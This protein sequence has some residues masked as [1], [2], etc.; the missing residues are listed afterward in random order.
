M[1]KMSRKRVGFTLIE[2]LIVIAILG[3]LAVV[4]LVLINPG[5]RQAQARDAGRVSSVAQ[6]GRSIQAYYTVKSNLPDVATWA[7][8]LVTTGEMSVFPSGIAY[9]YN[10]VSACTTYVQPATFPTYCYNEDEANGNGAIIYSKAEST[11]YRSK[12]NTPEETYFVFSTEDSRGGVI[13]SNGDPTP[14]VS[15]SMTYQP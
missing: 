15:G 1:K 12:C 10:S 9:T 2:L 11:T 4:V 3:I 5:E 7:A 14:W 6:L 8:D 13:C